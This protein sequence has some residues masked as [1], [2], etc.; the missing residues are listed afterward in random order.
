MNIFLM[1]QCEI[2]KKGFKIKQQK[3]G[4]NFLSLCFNLHEVTKSSNI[5]LQPGSGWG[6]IWIICCLDVSAPT[7]MNTAGLICSPEPKIHVFIF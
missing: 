5:S 2:K 1:H 3:I 6:D 7:F 4:K